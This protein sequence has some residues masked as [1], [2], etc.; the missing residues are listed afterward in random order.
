MERRVKALV[1][2]RRPAKSLFMVELIYIGIDNGLS[3]AIAALAAKDG[4]ILSLHS[5]PCTVVRMEYQAPEPTGKKKK[6]PNTV[7]TFNEIDG[8]KLVEVVRSIVGETP[9]VLVL[10]ECPEHAAQKSI[11]RSM[12]TSYG[13]IRGAL[14][15]A[16]PQCRMVLV[17][18]GNPLD[19]WQRKMLQINKFEKGAAKPASLALARSLWPEESW[20]PTPR[21]KVPDSGRVDAALI[22][23]H[24]R[25]E[26][27]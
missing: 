22:A 14:A 2:R 9:A 4:R 26:Q 20:L 16:M 13:I 27:L 24:A 10:E 12:A 7:R 18:A 11:M 21:S 3:G 8:L 1:T 25:R 17:R 23:E 15:A 5:M 19:S 6:K